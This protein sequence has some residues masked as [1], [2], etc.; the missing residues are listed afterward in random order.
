MKYALPSGFSGVLGQ[1]AFCPADML[2]F[3]TWAAGSKASLLHIPIAILGV[4][5]LFAGFHLTA[6][7]PSLNKPVVY[8]HLSPFSLRGV[9]R[10]YLVILPASS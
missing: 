3:H 8:V 7:P 10:G 9:N 4:G 6:D 5:R 2:T 1:T